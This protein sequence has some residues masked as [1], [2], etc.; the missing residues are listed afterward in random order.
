[1]AKHKAF[2]K[3]KKHRAKEKTREHVKSESK[4]ENKNI[5][6]MGVSFV[7][8][9][10]LVATVVYYNGNEK[11]TVSS[12]QENVG[13]IAN[14]TIN[15]INNELLQGR[16]R[17][18]LLNF[19]TTKYSGL[20]HIKISING[21]TY[22]SYVTSDGKLLF[23]SGINVTTTNSNEQQE[24]ENKFSAPKTDV[25]DVKLFVMAY[26]PF[27]LQSEKAMIPVYNL[28]K[29][30][31]NIT[32]N[33]VIYSNY[34]KE[35]LD[36]GTYCSMHG[37]SELTE[38]IRQLCI[39]KIYGKDKLWAYLDK[40]DHDCTYQNAK[41]CWKTAE[42]S[43]GIDDSLIQE[44]I[45]KEKTEFTMLK[46]EKSLNAKYNVRGSPTLIINGKVYSGERTP[47]DYKEAICSAFN[48]KPD[49][50]NENLSSETASTGFGG[51]SGTDSGGQ[52]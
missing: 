8:L 50:C 4:R 39:N 18:K 26:C 30:K 16:A 24:N 45:D 51:G 36:N 17:A 31:A 22:D 5:V 14:N 38:D 46:N 2:K 49:E 1:M 48:N 29:D 43:V 6:W 32:L 52:C 15:F 37:G 42:D 13:E 35:C 19:S 34:G 11:H 21:Q 7:L 44:C 20:Y 10:L 40:F 9:L 28:L 41:D 27:G 33:Y 3:N 47:E 12:S 25:P 23:P